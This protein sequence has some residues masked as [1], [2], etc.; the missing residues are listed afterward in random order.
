MRT[1]I[2]NNF[3]VLVFDMCSKYLLDE[4]FFARVSLLP[5][6]LTISRCCEPWRDDNCARSCLFIFLV[7]FIAIEVQFPIE[8]QLVVT[9]CHNFVEFDKRAHTTEKKKTKKNRKKKEK[10]FGSSATIS[11][12]RMN[13]LSQ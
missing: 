12:T 3:N 11:T 6:A 13:V 8:C 2:R 5:F 4:V 10:R 9:H 7:N 1:Y